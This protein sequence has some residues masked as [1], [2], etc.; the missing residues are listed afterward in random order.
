MDKLIPPGPSRPFELPAHFSIWIESQNT[1]AHLNVFRVHLQCDGL[2]K[3]LESKAFN[4]RKE[5]DAAR[6]WLEFM[7]L[8]GNILIMSVMPPDMLQHFHPTEGGG[9]RIVTPDKEE[10]A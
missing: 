3:T 6:A 2:N 10:D 5:Q 7:G 8:V 9:M 4:P 1:F